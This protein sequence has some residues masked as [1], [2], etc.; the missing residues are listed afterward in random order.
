MKLTGHLAVFVALLMLLQILSIHFIF[1]AN[2]LDS[3][4]TNEGM[5]VG[6]AAVTRTDN[7]YNIKPAIQDNCNGKLESIHEGRNY[8]SHPVTSKEDA[9][10]SA[11]ERKDGVNIAAAICHPTLFGTEIQLERLFAFVSYYRLLGF[12]HIFFWYTPEIRTL[13]HFDELQAFSYVT[14]TEYVPAADEKYYGQ[15]DV[16]RAC[17]NEQEY[18]ANY[19]F[20]LSIDAD[21]YLWFRNRMN[22]KEFL[23]QHKY[24]TYNY[25]SIGKW[26]YTQ[27][28]S[29]E[30][31]KKDSGFGL[32]QYAFTGGSFCRGHYGETYC[33]TYKGRCKILAKPSVYP[34][35]SFQLHGLLDNLN[36]SDAIHL[37]TSEAHFKEWRTVMIWNND[38]KIREPTEFAVSSDEEVNIHKNL[39]I[40][41][42][43]VNGKVLFRFDEHLQDWFRFVASGCKI[44]S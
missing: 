16:M 10:L 3:A 24:Q 41:H 13:D 2:T 14:L 6:Q 1:F 4:G 18:A 43:L 34:Y 40:S 44:G 11:C 19:D 17:L 39:M 20:A 25:F 22:V 26:T 33:P 12:D 36:A 15:R 29:I 9:L 35:P 5:L 37:D 23:S 28:H 32:D 31:T 30:M 27:M 21:E 38:Y 42:K 7:E 8:T